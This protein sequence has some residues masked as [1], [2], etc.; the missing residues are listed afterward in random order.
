MNQLRVSLKMP[1][2]ILQMTFTIQMAKFGCGLLS[3]NYSRPPDEVNKDPLIQYPTGIKPYMFKALIGRGHP[4]FSTKR[5]Q[6]AQEYLLHIIN[7]IERNS[8]RDLNP[9]ACFK[10]EVE[11]RI[12]CTQSH[13][14]KYTKRTDY[15]LP[16]PI[17]MEAATNLDEVAAFEAKKKQLQAEKKVIDPKDMVR[18]RISLKS[19]LEAFGAA[20]LIDDFYSSALKS[21]STAKKITR[22]ATFP[23]YLMIQMKKFTLGDDWVPMKLDVSLDMPDEL[24]LSELRGKGLQPGEVELPDGDQQASAEPQIDEAVVNQLVDMGFSREGCKR[25]VYNT[26]NSGI[27]PAMNWIMEHMA[28]PDFNSPFQVPGAGGAKKGDSFVANE[29]ALT[30]IT[31]MGFTCE[32]AIKALK[33]TDNNVE[34]AA[35]W[36]FS[37]ADELDQPMETDQDQPEQN[38]SPKCHDGNSRYKLVAFISHMGTSTLVGHYVCHILKEGRW[39]IYNDEKVALSEHPPKD[40]AYLYLYQ[41]I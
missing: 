8:Y 27:E 7:M 4:E 38:T 17:P 6:D 1:Q 26:N 5:Q 35:D 40:L 23:D 31:S 12:E 20:E 10:Y 14:V 15:L 29:E 39:V 25:A 18:P 16:L 19:C 21:T 11:E 36:I 30:M 32:Q 9:T 13:Q 28:D 2:L 33:A 3:G 41:R 22:L 37:H 34:R 24:D